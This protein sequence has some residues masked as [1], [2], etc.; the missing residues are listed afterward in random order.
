MKDYIYTIA[1]VLTSVLRTLFGFILFN[2]V[3]TVCAVLD[4]ATG[5]LLVKSGRFEEEDID[6]YTTALAEA[7]KSNYEYFSRV[8]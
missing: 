8:R 4:R 2:P 7:V 5:T 3:L 6:E 1:I